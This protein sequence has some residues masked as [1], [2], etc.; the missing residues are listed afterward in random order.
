MKTQ[1]YIVRH[2]TTEWNKQGRIQGLTDIELS[3]E[4]RAQARELAQSFSTVPFAAVISSDL[5]RAYQTA[6]IIGQ[7]LQLPVETKVTLRERSWDTWE[8]WLVDDLRRQYSEIF[9]SYIQNPTQEKPVD[10]PGIAKVETY[11]QVMQRVIPCLQ[12]IARC[13]PGQKVLIISHGGV[14]KG[15][16]LHLKHPEFIQPVCQ[17]GCYLIL[18]ASDGTL[19]ILKTE[20]IHER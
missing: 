20:G 14:L 3:E 13:Y 15:L 7:G 4:G 18:E 11:R 17:N 12:E 16:M 6:E 19:Q 5:Q 9:D 2:G 10:L 1:L 8:G